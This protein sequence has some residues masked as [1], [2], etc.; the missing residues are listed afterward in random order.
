MTYSTNMLTVLSQN[1]GF[2]N[3][4][5][6]HMKLIMKRGKQA[7]VLRP[8]DASINFSRTCTNINKLLLLFVFSES[9][10]RINTIHF[11]VLKPALLVSSPNAPESTSCQSC[12]DSHA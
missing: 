5:T 6:T 11:K 2:T 4:H 3:D 12:D 1:P 7:Y 9:S 10:K 8:E